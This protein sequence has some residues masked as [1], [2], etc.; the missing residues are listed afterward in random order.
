LNCFHSSIAILNQNYSWFNIFKNAIDDWCVFIDVWAVFTLILGLLNAC[1]TAK[2]A[3]ISAFC[4][5]E[6]KL[7]SA[8]FES[9]K[10]CQQ[11]RLNQY[12]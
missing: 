1:G 2:P 8:K 6:L 5:G 10:I 4:L 7:I 11:K 12:F 3:G 9:V